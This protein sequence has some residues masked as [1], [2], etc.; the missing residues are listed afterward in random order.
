VHRAQHIYAWLLYGLAWVGELRSQLNYLRSGMQDGAGTD[1][2]AARARSF[3]VE[4][5]LCG[6]VLLP[7]AW[8]IG[9]A[10]L[11]ML[12]LVSMTLGSAV[13]AVILVVGHINTGLSPT[14]DAPEGRE[15]WAAHLL[16]TSASF[17]TQNRLTRWLTGGMTHHLAHHLRATA[18]RGELPTLHSTTVVELAAATGAP[19]VEY[20]T[21]ASAVAGHW[22][23]LRDLGRPEVASDGALDPVAPPLSAR[24]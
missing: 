14:S 13:A 9:P 12:L 17:S 23:A 21:L 18:P 20:P 2:R 6:V 8:F 11:A 3:A 16:R 1:G 5:A 15:A 7:Y 4:K 10:R 22:R 24:T 19:V